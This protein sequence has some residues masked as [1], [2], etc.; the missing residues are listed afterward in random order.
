MT[1]RIRIFILFVC[2][3]GLSSRAMAQQSGTDDRRLWV[4]TL[5]RI[6]DPVLT[7]LSNNIL[8]KNM[9]YESLS[10]DR[11]EFSHL[12]AVGRLI[13]GISPWLELGPDDTP[14]GQLRKKYIDLAVK[15]LKNAV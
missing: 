9:P 7:N 13:C 12:E 6:A 5:T 15:G 14:E 11:H 10:K 4:E 1:H 2:L 8:K 3:V